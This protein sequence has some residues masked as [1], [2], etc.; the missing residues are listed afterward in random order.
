M[1][2]EDV[3]E[4]V[5]YKY[6]KKIYNEECEKL[7]KD[8]LA[9][10]E[11]VDLV[12]TTYEEKEKSLR[13]RIKSAIKQLCSKEEFKSDEEIDKLLERIFKDPNFNKTKIIQEVEI[14]QSLKWLIPKYQ[15]PVQFCIFLK[16]EAYY[17]RKFIKIII[18][19]LFQ[20]SSFFN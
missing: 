20:D 17:N 6:V 18:I 7:K 16:E 2:P 1:S 11:I 19:I 15:A 9:R 5:I 10:T 12:T 8:K 13:H 14:Q 3:A 4:Q